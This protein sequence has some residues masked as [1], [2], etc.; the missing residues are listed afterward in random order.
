MLVREP[1]GVFVVLYL[2]KGMVLCH[3]QYLFSKD[4]YINSLGIERLLFLELG[5]C[6]WG[7]DVELFETSRLVL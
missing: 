1:S 7:I 3:D 4:L 5:R 2:A 6:D